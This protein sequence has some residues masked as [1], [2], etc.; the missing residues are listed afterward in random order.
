VAIRLR[1]CCGLDSLEWI[2]IY[3]L[4]PMGMTLGGYSLARM[5]LVGFAE[6]DSQLGAS[7]YGNDVGGY[8]LARVLIFGFA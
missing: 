2:P 1:E 6:M 8:S 4:R 5:L 7:P 3:G